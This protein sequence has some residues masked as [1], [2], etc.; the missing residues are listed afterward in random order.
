MLAGDFCP[1]L[2]G[3][4]DGFGTGSRLG[5]QKG[6]LPSRSIRLQFGFEIRSTVMTSRRI[7][8]SLDERYD[9]FGT[10]GQV[11]ATRMRP[12]FE[13]HLNVAWLVRP[14]RSRD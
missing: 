9:G 11:G 12:A 5:L 1:S 13:T 10:V 14:S 7:R 8:L 4:Y 6:D 3:R 2:D